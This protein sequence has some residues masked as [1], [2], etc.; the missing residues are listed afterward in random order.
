MSGASYRQIQDS[1]D[2]SK[3]QCITYLKGLRV[4]DLPAS[5]KDWK[6]AELEA[7]QVLNQKGFSEIHDLNTFANAPFWDLLAKKKDVWWLI[8]VTVSANKTIGSKFPHLN[9]EY[10]Y[11]LLYKNLADGSWTLMRMS[12][13]EES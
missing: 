10:T 7:V 1:L 2:V 8:D 4:D 11:A 13:H 6:A 5:E 3:G 9:G 12:M